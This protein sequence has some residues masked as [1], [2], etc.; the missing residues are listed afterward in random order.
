MLYIIYIYRR[1]FL[2]VLSGRQST[3][4]IRQCNWEIKDKN[5]QNNREVIRRSQ[6]K[7]AGRVQEMA[8]RQVQIQP[9]EDKW[10]QGNR[11]W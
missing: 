1:R 4:K 2:E 8:G 10:G 3:T 7:V 9:T 11:W 6:S 5:G